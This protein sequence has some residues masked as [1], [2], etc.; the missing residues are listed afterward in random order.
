MAVCLELKNG[1]IVYA[2]LKYDWF[3]LFPVVPATIAKYRETFTHSGAKDDPTDAFLMVDFMQRHDD[4]LRVITPDDEETRI[5]QRM[6]VQR[7]LLVSEKI[8]LTNRITRALKDF[9][10]QSLDW[11]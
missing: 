11:F 10:P 5:L 6:V 2:L 7:R 9:Y 3:D 4:K 1:P 8:R